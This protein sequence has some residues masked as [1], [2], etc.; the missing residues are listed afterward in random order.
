MTF[1]IVEIIVPP[2]DFFHGETFNSEQL[3]CSLFYALF[4]FFSPQNLEWEVKNSR[5][6]ST[7]SLIKTINAI[8][9]SAAQWFD[10]L[11]HTYVLD[12]CRPKPA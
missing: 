9:E 6:H 8:Y 3:Q 4:V 11:M 1:S 7:P 12:T 2:G 5:R 10:T